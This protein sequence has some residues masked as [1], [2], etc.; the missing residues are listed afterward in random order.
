MPTTVVEVRVFTV[1][2]VIVL[3]D[4][5]P[6]TIDVDVA[7]LT[8]ETVLRMKELQND[9]ADGADLRFAMAV[10]EQRAVDLEDEEEVDEGA[11]LR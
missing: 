7:V 5:V 2:V 4:V 10:E 8:A 3:A 1:V 11:G 9:W 6:V